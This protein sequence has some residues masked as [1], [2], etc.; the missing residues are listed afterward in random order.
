M[1]E[2]DPV[3]EGVCLQRFLFLEGF[4]PGASVALPGADSAGGLGLEGSGC[5][6]LSWGR[7]RRREHTSLR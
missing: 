6:R 2:L 4:A 1:I 3:R 7:G 5:H